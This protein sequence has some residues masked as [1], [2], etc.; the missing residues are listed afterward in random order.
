[1]H[2]DQHGT[3]IISAAALLNALEIAEKDIQDVR[4]VVSG[5]GAAAISCTRLYQS[6]GAKRENIVMLDSK[7]VIRNDRDNLTAQK[8]EFAT[9]RKID[10]L[11]QAMINAD[12]FI[13][14]STSNIVSQEMLK[15]MASNP[16]V[17]AMA[18]PDPEIKYKLA[19]KTRDDIIM[20]TGRSDNPNQVNNVLGFP[21][22][23]R[24]ALDVR[25]R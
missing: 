19:I 20:A 5:A 8:A 12:V 15:T 13:G 6:F 21:F 9:K 11:D 4:I 14:L 22:I 2:D 25:G 16:I 3:A 1:M 18:N 10:S 7:G 23:F 17:F 24:G